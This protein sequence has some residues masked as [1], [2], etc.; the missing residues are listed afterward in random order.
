MSVLLKDDLASISK[1]TGTQI[2]WEVAV[3]VE[4]GARAGMGVGL[5]AAALVEVGEEVGV[6]G[7]GVEVGGEGVGMGAAA[8]VVGLGEEARAEE[9]CITKQMIQN[10]ETARSIKA[11]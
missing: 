6:E 11:L 5:G 10:T 9:G 3:L 7:V 1:G 2:T 8:E 4:A